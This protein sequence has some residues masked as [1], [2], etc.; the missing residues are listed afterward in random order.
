MEG[1]DVPW[2]SLQGVQETAVSFKAG[3]TQLS[4]SGVM[5]HEGLGVGVVL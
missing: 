3:G 1:E 2:V 5:C 4:L